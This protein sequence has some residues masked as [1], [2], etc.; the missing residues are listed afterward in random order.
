MK[1]N[2]FEIEYN[3]KI[4]YLITK[5]L[6]F[7]WPKNY[8]EFDLRHAYK[9]SIFSNDKDLIIIQKVRNYLRKVKIINFKK[10]DYERLIRILSGKK[11]VY[12]YKI[13]FEMM[14]IDYL[15]D[16]VTYLRLQDDFNLSFYALSVMLIYVFQKKNEIIIPYRA[17]I[18]RMLDSKEIE[19][20]RE[21]ELLKE[22]TKRNNIKHDVRLN[23]LIR[24]IIKDKRDEFLDTF[25]SVSDFGIF[26]SFSMNKET[27]YSDLDMLVISN[28]KSYVLERDIYMYWKNYFDIPMDIKIVKEDEI[29]IELTECMKKTL[30]MVR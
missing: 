14:N 27:E 22:R 9:A 23:S 8:N 4:D 29:E 16:Y 13:D 15:S 1:K 21:L 3:P 30:K 10:E 11:Y 18:K 7:N 6:L 26:G 2:F 12:H 5:N 20:R 25:K 17:Q 28:D 24:K 19:I